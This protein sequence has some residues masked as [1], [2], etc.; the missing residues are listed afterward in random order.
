MHSNVDN[1]VRMMDDQE[2]VSFMGST[3]NS[4]VAHLGLMV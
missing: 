4:R 2:L 1:V 3:T